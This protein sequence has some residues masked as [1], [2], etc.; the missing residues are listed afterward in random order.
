M[1]NP[2][3]SAPFVLYLPEAATVT[4]GSPLQD[5]AGRLHNGEEIVLYNLGGRGWFGS[6]RTQPD[7]VVLYD[8]YVY[9]NQMIYNVAFS[10]QNGQPADAAVLGAL[11]RVYCMPGQNGSPAGQT[12]AAAMDALENGEWDSM[13]QLLAEAGGLDAGNWAVP[14]LAGRLAEY[15][16][17]LLAARGLYAQASNLWPTDIELAARTAS[18]ESLAVD[19][20][21]GVAALGA[22]AAMSPEEAV[23]WEELGRIFLAAE[24]F[25]VAKSYF[26]EAA[27]VNP[28]SE[29][30]LYNLSFLHAE[31]GEY[32]DALRRAREF[33]HF[34]PWTPNGTVPDVT[35]APGLGDSRVRAIL[36]EPLPLGRIADYAGARQ[37]T[38]LPLSHP[39]VEQVLQVIHVP[40]HTTVYQPSPVY[41]PRVTF[42]WLW[43]PGFYRP[44]LR[45]GSI[46]H[47]PRP[48]F[49]GHFR[50]GL[51]PP[52]P[53]PGPGIGPPPGGPPGDNNRPGTGSRPQPPSGGNRPQPPTEG[54]RPRPPTEGNRPQPPT[55]GNRPQP[56]AEGNRP[57]PPSAGNRPRPPEETTRPQPPSAG[58]RP[59]PP[60][61]GNR[62]QPPT[63]TR[64]ST[65]EASV[66]PLPAP[67]PTRPVTRPGIAV[68][69][70]TRPTV[71]E[72]P[73]VSPPVDRQ[74][75]LTDRTRPAHPTA[76]TGSVTR[77]VQPTTRPAQP[78][79][80][81]AQPTTRPAQPVTRPSQPTVRPETR[82]SQPAAGRTPSRPTVERP[83][84]VEQTARRSPATDARARPE[85]EVLEERTRQ[86]R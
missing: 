36:N 39:E 81:P 73:T 11:A 76:P 70:R 9:R 34:Y 46:G 26:D 24:D 28:S 49:G 71:P 19:G 51:T 18:M 60:S 30:A 75:N 66:R 31:A 12:V 65:P 40:V 6:R 67:L 44:W 83:S 33:V 20:D 62:P 86:R 63:T 52:R 42:G 13:E 37:F 64:P 16:Q 58:N 45:P 29:T 50:P 8:G 27:A 55:G 10:L 74:P 21:N 4:N 59:Q 77:P 57:Q 14:F 22:L 69:D 7:G 38:I 3:E 80:R 5:I 79:T 68:P 48:P 32:D 54:N 43:H 25:D 84:R 41:I 56:P 23:I 82:P 2:Y 78:T 61:A 35:D 53:G 15:N 17:D 72:R 1:V 47:R 85:R